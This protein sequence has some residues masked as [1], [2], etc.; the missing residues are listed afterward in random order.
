MRW[1]VT[2]SIPLPSRQYL[3][4]KAPASLR[5]VGEAVTGVE[6]GDHVVL[7]AAFCGTCKQCRSGNP[8]YCLNVFEEDFGGQRR[9]GT[10]SLSKNGERISSHFF[11]QSSFS[12]YANVV[13]ESL[14]VIDKDVPLDIVGRSDADSPR[15]RVRYSMSSNRHRGSRSQSLVPAP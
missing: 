3:G 15:A 9:D 1:Y 2:E 8:A 4:T 7:A 11:G 12:T 13:A 6:V 5:K 14:V 10:T